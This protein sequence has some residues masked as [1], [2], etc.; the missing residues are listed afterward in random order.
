MSLSPI[1]PSPLADA[2]ELC[3]LGV[4]DLTAR[5]RAGTLS[6][7][8]AARACLDRAAAIN[9]RFNA[10]TLI[11][12]DG[13]L[14]AARASEARWRAGAPVSAIDGVPTTIKDILWV[15]GWTIRYGSRAFSGITP[16]EDA[17]VVRL[18]RDAGAV[19]LGLTTTPEFGWKAVTDSALTGVTRNPWHQERTPGGSSGGAAVAA[20]TGAG[21]LHVGTDGG[22]SIRIPAGFTGI[23]GHKPTFSRV[24]AY[25]ASPFGTVAHIGPMARTVADT[26]LMLAVMSGRDGR[27]WYQ[28]P[29]SFPPVTPLAPRPLAGLRVGVW[30]APP[31]GAVAPDV[32]AVF[33]ATLARLGDAGAALVPVAL[34][35]EDLWELFSA[36]WYPGAAARLAGL[37]A[38][39]LPLVEPGLRAI[40]EAGARYSSVEILDAAVRRAQFGAAFDRLLA[41]YDVIVSPAVALTA[42]TAG[43]EVPE[44]SGMTRWTEWAG[45]SYPI[46][47]SQ[48]PA[49]VVPAGF[50]ADGLPVGLQVIARRGDDAGALAAAA[51]FESLAA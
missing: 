27:D 36:H 5:Y 37:P 26:A 24:P 42:F 43:L 47:L 44:A 30:D 29:L 3:R 4:A 38:E 25:P 8:E 31:R 46:N 15:N 13:A 48:A 22:G 19:P 34:P 40:A 51:A 33:A 41:E 50:G 18:L 20:A 17:P 10:F 28:N 14:A 2:P 49:T 23:V 9:P 16:T 6:P 12:A 1:R 32:R 35:G 11:D 45:F 7:V 39:A 21:V